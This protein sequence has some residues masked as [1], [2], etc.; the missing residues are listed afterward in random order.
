M[1]SPKLT[2]DEIEAWMARRRQPAIAMLHTAKPDDE[3]TP[4]CWFGG[5]PT[6][7]PDVEWPIYKHRQSGLE[8]PHHFLA[9]INLAYV[10]QVLG[11][12]P[13]P[14]KGTL[15]VFYE[16]RLAPIGI[17]DE[18]ATPPLQSGE[19]ARVIFVDHDTS[20][21]PTRRPPP[22][23]DLSVLPEDQQWPYQ[24]ETTS[25]QK[26]NFEFVVVETYPNPMCDNPFPSRDLPWGC[27]SRVNALEAAEQ[28]QLIKR[29]F[30][31]T[32]LEDCGV[33]EIPLHYIFG[34]ADTRRMPT[35]DAVGKYA[36]QR[37]LRPI[38]EDHIQLFKFACDDIGKHSLQAKPETFWINRN[39]LETQN[40]DDIIVWED[41]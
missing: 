2:D 6:L 26:W 41:H 7:P 25:Y 18:E 30:G 17:F 14:K 36:Y 20:T 22:M 21:Y 12:P 39:D 35:K 1:N 38:S 37:H 16:Q 32:R 10:P 9:Q 27:L 19:G 3:G 29:R 15:F 34:A 28:E 4:G 5:D 24:F 13:L 8:L 11:L 33:V 31:C 23:P 40:F